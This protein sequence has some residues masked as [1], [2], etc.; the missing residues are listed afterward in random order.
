MDFKDYIKGKRHGK[1]ANRIERDALNDPFLHDAI[2]GFDSVEGDHTQ[3]IE[4]L[5]KRLEQRVNKSP[6]PNNNRFWTIGIAASL[7]LL[8]GIGSLL[9]LNRTIH[10]DNDAIVAMSGAADTANVAE[11]LPLAMNKEKQAADEKAPET[12]L[13]TIEAP[14]PP[15]LPI[16]PPGAE[17]TIMPSPAG[18]GV[19]QRKEVAAPQ[20]SE[21][22]YEEVYEVESVEMAQENTFYRSLASEETAVSDKER[23]L[24]PNAVERQHKKEQASDS[25][26]ASRSMKAVQAQ[27]TLSVRVLDAVTNKPLQG[28]KAQ[29]KNSSLVLHTDSVG[30]FKLPYSKSI[31]LILS[32]EGYNTIEVNLLPGIKEIHMQPAF[33]E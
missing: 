11:G 5:E 2:E 33:P 26:M 7:V 18:A 1:E 31:K 22:M 28:V 23:A 6:K 24:E 15:A 20:M 19:E 9:L 25:Y 10:M 29:K 8:I 30:I 21:N 16:T 13:Q 17:I 14:V 12:K 4:E 3:A 27:D 32:A